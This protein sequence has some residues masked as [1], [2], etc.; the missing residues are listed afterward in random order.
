[1]MNNFTTSDQS[2]T[3]GRLIPRLRFTMLSDDQPCIQVAPLQMKVGP[4]AID[5]VLRGD[6]ELWRF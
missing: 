3:Y 5:K 1:M 2:I 4:G 6:H